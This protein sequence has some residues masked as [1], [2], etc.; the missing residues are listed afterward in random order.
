MQVSILPLDFQFHTD[1]TSK[2]DGALHL[3]SS[4][5]GMAMRHRD[6]E[7]M[8]RIREFSEKFFIEHGRSPSTSEIGAVMSMNKTTV[9]RYLVEMAEK[10]MIDYDGKTITTHKTAIAEHGVTTA[11]VYREAIPCGAPEIIEAAV[12]QF[13]QLPSII[14]GSGN[15]FIIPA[16]GDSMIEAGIDDGDMVVVDA[17]REASIGDKVVALD[18]EGQ[19][20]LKTLHY[21][22][23][24][25]RYFLHPENCKLKDIYVDEL[26]IQGVVRFII[27]KG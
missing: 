11:R 5:G 12:D 25:S 14:F 8:R 4:E 22:K 19:S 10:G 18:G 13:V 17:D 1:Y 27:K 9:H 16:H 26:T 6:T 23:E 3:E 20:T 7:L 15:L 21:D 24:Q 2:C